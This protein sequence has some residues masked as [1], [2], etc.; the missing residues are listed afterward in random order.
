[1]GHKFLPS[2]R[3]AWTSK[4]MAP[5][6]TTCSHAPYGTRRVL[7]ALAP[8][9]GGEIIDA[10]LGLYHTYDETEAALGSLVSTYPTLADTIRIG[11][12]YGP[13]FRNITVIKISDNVAVDENE[14]EVLFSGCHHARELMS[15]EIPLM[16]ATYLLQNYGTDPTVTNYVNT[17]EIYCLPILNPDGL[18]YVQANHSGSNST[19]WRK[20]R[21]NN[22]DGTFGVDL[23]RNYAFAWGYDNIGSSP[24]TS[25]ATYRGPGAFSEPETRA[26]RDFI[27]D[28]EFTIWLSYHTYGELFLYPW[29]YVPEFTPD[30]KV[31]ASL[32]AEMAEGTGYVVG[33]TALGT[34]YLTNGGSDDWAYGEIATKN[35]IFSFTPETNNSGQGGF[36]PAE[37]Y[38]QPTF[39]LLLNMNLTALE[40]ANNPYR[41]IGPERPGQYAVQGA[42]LEW[43]QPRVVDRERSFRPEPGR[44]VRRRGVPES[45][46][47]GRHV[48]AVADRL[49]QQWLLVQR[50]RLQRRG[51]QRRNRQ[52]HHAH[53]PDGA[54]HPGRCVHGHAALQDQL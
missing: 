1:M 36:A 44:V 51:L 27:E 29:G 45:D 15:V 25:N 5:P 46:A 28:R 11:R 38:I 10:N 49:G 24:S 54:P 12:A 9:P 33:N 21:R 39:N 37:S 34:I 48:H 53:A 7:P 4:L 23:N 8:P 20:N 43:R 30:Q 19:W 41:V 18:S 6:W 42:V 26:L 13:T 31:F 32:G 2:R 47:V 17:R 22:G 16:F 52:Q 3:T 40:Y 50:E 35:R 14:A